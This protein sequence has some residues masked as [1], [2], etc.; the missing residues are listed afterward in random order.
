MIYRLSSTKWFALL[1]C[2]R[3]PQHHDQG[4]CWELPGGGIDTGETFVAPALG[5]A[6]ERRLQN[7]IESSTERF[8]PGSLQKYVRRVLEGERIDEP[9][10]CFS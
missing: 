10:E 8:Y 9:F 6:G 3:E 2:I 7:E 4:R 5:H 1:L